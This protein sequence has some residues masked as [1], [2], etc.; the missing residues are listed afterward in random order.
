ML[1]CPYAHLIA[2]FVKGHSMQATTTPGLWKQ[3]L[4]PTIGSIL[5]RLSACRYSRLL[6][7][8]QSCTKQCVGTF[9][10]HGLQRRSAKTLLRGKRMPVSVQFFATCSSSQIRVSVCL[11][12]VLGCVSLG[13]KI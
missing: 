3:Y 13:Y 5:R 6:A 4:Q 9:S 1:K 12:A 2:D 10:L 8:V 7:S 11:F